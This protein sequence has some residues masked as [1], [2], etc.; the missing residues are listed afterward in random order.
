[1]N[2]PDVMCVR[3]PK[4]T[5]KRINLLKKETRAPRA[6]L[7]RIIFFLGLQLVERTGA[8]GRYHVTMDIIDGA[9]Y[10]PVITSGETLL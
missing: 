6:E 3:T 9:V 8:M 2:Y 1:M 4:G 5:G 7:L 10:N